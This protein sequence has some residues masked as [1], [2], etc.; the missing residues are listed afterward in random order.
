MKQH[1]KR[2]DDKTGKRERNSDEVKVNKDTE[3][4][5]TKWKR[6]WED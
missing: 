4:R 5:R 2:L 1:V 6:T 3:N